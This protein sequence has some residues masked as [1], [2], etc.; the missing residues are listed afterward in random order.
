MYYPNF[1]VRDKGS[2]KDQG[3]KLKT[4]V[5]GAC[6]Q[7]VDGNIIDSDLD[8]DKVQLFGSIRDDSCHECTALQQ[9]CPKS[10]FEG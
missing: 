3:V 10:S 5:F 8:V 2:V 9:Q 1:K 6:L 7:I 4:G